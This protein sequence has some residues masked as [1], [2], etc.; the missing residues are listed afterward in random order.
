MERAGISLKR[1]SELTGYN[2]STLW[3]AIND[4]KYRRRLSKKFWGRI[5]ATI[6]WKVKPLALQ[7]NDEGIVAIRCPHCKTIF[8]VKVGDKTNI[9]IEPIVPEAAKVSKTM[10]K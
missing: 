3:H 9:E 1:M 10:S 8:R 6:R 4:T 2:K 5:G 7:L